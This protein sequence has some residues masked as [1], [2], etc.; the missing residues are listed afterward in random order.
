MHQLNYDLPENLTLTFDLPSSVPMEQRL[1]VAS[2]GWQRRSSSICSGGPD[3]PYEQ[4]GVAA[5]VQCCK[6]PHCPLAT[7]PPSGAT[8][9]SEYDYSGG[10]DSESTDTDWDNPNNQKSNGMLG[11]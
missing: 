7:L 10:S 1:S 5:P 3:C 9:V 4:A 11:T 6:Q 2:P 8:T